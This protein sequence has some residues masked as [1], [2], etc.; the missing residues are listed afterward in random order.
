[1]RLRP[2]F[3]V[4]AGLTFA[5]CDS[6]GPE[7]ELFDAAILTRDAALLVGTWDL[8]RVS[9][10]DPQTG[11][12][13]SGPPD[14]HVRLGFGADGTFEMY[15][16]DSLVWESTFTVEEVCSQQTG[17]CRNELFFD[18]ISDQF[19]FWIGNYN[20]SWVGV[21]EEWLVFDARPVDGAELVY[22]SR[23]E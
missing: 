20:Q 19:Q 7:T 21:N 4:L 10:Y 14:E 16:A 9:V 18:D 23:T 2:V 3:F 1:M 8:E 22:R 6:A 12:P 17:Q 13:T 15:R 11:R 5:A